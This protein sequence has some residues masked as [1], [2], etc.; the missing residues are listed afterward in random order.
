M[1]TAR[2]TVRPGWSGSTSTHA[3]V[4]ESRG[5]ESTRPVR[6]GVIGVGDFGERHVRAYARQPGV[7]LV[8][9]ADSDTERARSVAGRWGI[10]RWFENA[11][12]LLDETGPDGISVVTPGEHHLA[13]TLTALEHDCA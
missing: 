12:R 1:A 3:A 8:G 13:P 2:S 4:P 10:E 5:R 11:E 6:V 9:I 7:S